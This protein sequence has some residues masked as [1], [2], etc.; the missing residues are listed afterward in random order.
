MGGC[1][2]E[3]TKLLTLASNSLFQ[4]KEIGK[5]P[6]MRSLLFHAL[7]LIR[8]FFKTNGH[9]LLWGGGFAFEKGISL[10]LSS[11]HFSLSSH[12][13]YAKIIKGY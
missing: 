2:L 7:S 4:T 3:S 5:N 10:I 9:I 6:K 1:N 11:T 13:C 8:K 12:V